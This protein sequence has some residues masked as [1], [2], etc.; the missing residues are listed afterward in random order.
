MTNPEIAT[1]PLLDDRLDMAIRRILPADLNFILNSWKKSYRQ[2]RPEWESWFYFQEMERRINTVLKRNPRVRLAVDPRDP[3]YIYGWVVAEAPFLHYIY[4]K[5]SY[6]PAGVV[7]RLF[8]ESGL[9]ACSEIYATHWTPAAD[10]LQV[11]L[12]CIVNIEI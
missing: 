1:S 2:A 7:M 5:E 10:R 3:N 9:A 11:K 8:A 6:R 4:V 12:P